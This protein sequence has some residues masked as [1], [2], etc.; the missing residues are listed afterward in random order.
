MRSSVWGV[1]LRSVLPFSEPIARNDGSRTMAPELGRGSFLISHPGSTARVA[2]VW[3]PQSYGSSPGRE[4]WVLYTPTF[5]VPKTT[6]T[7][8]TM[9]YE[10][11]DPGFA[12]L[13]TDHRDCF[14][15]WVIDYE[16]AHGGRVVDPEDLDVW[17]HTA[18]FFTANPDNCPT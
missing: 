18:T 13:A 6:T 2:W 8:V 17:D 14:V 15:K 4:V 3:S 16:L 10:S 12:G 11:A 1:F 5:V 9:I 7:P